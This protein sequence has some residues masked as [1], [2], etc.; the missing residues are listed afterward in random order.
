MQRFEIRGCQL[1]KHNMKHLLTFLVFFAVLVSFSC[2]KDIAAGTPSCI[3]KEIKL[4]FQNRKIGSVDEYSYQGKTVYAFSP[5]FSIITDGS[6]E[7]T[8]EKCNS[9]CS[10]GGFG[11]PQATLCNGE[12]FFQKAVLVRNIW[13]KK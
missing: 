3:K 2:N 4:N 13:K 9:I 8:D 12:N 1:K 7:I 5:D 11:G 10:V 6:T